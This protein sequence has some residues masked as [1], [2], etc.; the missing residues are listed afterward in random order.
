MARINTNI[1]SLQAINRYTKNNN[2][3]NTHLERLS[4]GLRI[5]RGKDAPAGL[6]ASETLRSEIQGIRQAIDN[7]TRA[8]NVINTAE[9]ALS[10]VSSLLLELQSL[11]NEAANTGALSRQEIEANQLQVDSILNSINRISNTTQFNGVKLLNGSL[12]YIT[13]GVASTAIDVL[14]INSAKLP[15]NGYTTVTVQV[16]GSAHLANVTFNGTSIG[17]SAVTIE[18]SGNEGTEQLSFAAGTT[19]SAV[20]F[21]VNALKESTGVSATNT[22]T[23]IVFNS[24][25]YG[26]N[27]FVSI[28]TLEGTF[29]NGKDFG[30]DA[31]VS[32]NGTQASVDGLKASVRSGDLDIELHLDPTFGTTVSTAGTSFQITGG[33]AKFQIGSRVNRAGQIQIGI[34]SVAT[35]KLG[36]PVT[37]YLSSIGSGGNNSLVGGNT[38]Q[39]QKI[40]TEAI[41]QVST[42]RGRLG[43]LQKNVLETNINSLN[44]ALE[45]VT[46]SESA[47]RDADFAA[48]TAALTRSQILVQANTSVLAQANSNPQNVLALLQ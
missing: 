28:K 2:S 44:V 33:G 36:N 14:Q 37:G 7:T 24:T 19:A 47:I 5:N 43:A 4:S 40:I 30:Q 48:E 31:T 3:L 17:T 18:V 6:I 12:D 29:T 35:T 46:A 38:V 42:I 41:R 8:D 22:G 20:V 25:A 45:N 15:D 10:E 16:T 21:A 23:S 11:T 9:G 13:S 39:A 32:I 1:A 26:S 34:S 27:Q